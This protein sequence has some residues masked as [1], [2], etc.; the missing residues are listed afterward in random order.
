MV[1]EKLKY[2]RKE[3]P[4]PPLF[5]FGHSFLRKHSMLIRSPRPYLRRITHSFMI[6]HSSR[7]LLPISSCISSSNVT[8]LITTFSPFAG[9]PSKNPSSTPTDNA[10]E[11]FNQELEQMFGPSLS[12]DESGIHTDPST[13]GFPS[14]LRNHIEASKGNQAFIAQHQYL[15]QQ[16]QSINNNDHSSSYPTQGISGESTTVR[17]NAS[18]HNDTPPIHVHVNIPSDKLSSSSSS[19]L[20]SSSSSESGNSSSVLHIHVHVHITKDTKH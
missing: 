1:F 14:S 8:K 15:Q 12:T 6:L 16:N 18:T 19:S 5:F 17:A 11:E 3:F 7:V 2:M 20:S 13:V 4:F 10:A 9:V